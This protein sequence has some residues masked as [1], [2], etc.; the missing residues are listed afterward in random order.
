MD[1]LGCCTCY[2]NC[3]LAPSARSA[4]A[5]S[6]YVSSPKFGI[7]ECLPF[8]YRLS[9]QT[10]SKDWSMLLHLSTE[11]C[12]Q[13]KLKFLNWT[14][15]ADTMYRGRTVAFK[16]EDAAILAIT[17]LVLVQ[18]L[19]EAGENANLRPRSRTMETSTDSSTYIQKVLS[20]T[21]STRRY[22][23]QAR[24]SKH[25]LLTRTQ[26]SLLKSRTKLYYQSY[27]SASCRGDPSDRFHMEG[28]R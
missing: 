24:T 19:K 25:K 15:T 12:I 28:C 22:E 10:S 5:S 3:Q 18:C 7:L 20:I 23:V 2:P 8:N 27:S 9:G 16:H 14:I 6:H 11:T 26:R 17:L 4:S 21:S 13:L 1:Y